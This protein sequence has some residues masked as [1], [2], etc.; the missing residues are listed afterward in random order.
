MAFSI[1]SY[2]FSEMLS[3]PIFIRYYLKYGN[4][5]SRMTI[6]AQTID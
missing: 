2:R 5:M 1:F 4:E 3:I 6:D